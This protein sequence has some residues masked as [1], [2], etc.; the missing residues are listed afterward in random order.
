MGLFVIPAAIIGPSKTISL[1]GDWG[2]HFLQPA[3]VEGTDSTRSVELLGMTATDNQSIQGVLHNILNLDRST[4]PKTGSICIKVSHW[5]IGGLLTWLTL[6]VAKRSQLKEPFREALTLCGLLVPMLLISPVCHLHYFV[7][8]LPVVMTLIA[9]HLTFG[10]RVRPALKGA[11]VLVFFTGLLPRIP[12][13]EYS[14]DIGLA[15]VG[16]LA[17]WAATL[18]E[19]S[20]EAVLRIRL[21]GIDK[22]R[23]MWGRRKMITIHEAGQHPRMVEQQRRKAS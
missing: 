17:L 15:S 5:L 6:F 11:L 10:Q 19:L 21:P 14:R 22:A 8:L 9:S 13:L 3:L 2:R 16:A 7:L 12:G 18:I 1:Y 4:R 20:G 23:R